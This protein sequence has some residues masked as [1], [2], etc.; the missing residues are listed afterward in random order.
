MNSGETTDRR[1]DVLGVGVSAQTM[2]QAVETVA[3]WIQNR[4]RTYVCVADVHSVV[5][6][7]GD[8]ALRDIH[9]AA[10]MVTT[11]G[12]PLVWLCRLAGRRDAER[13]YGPDLMLAVCE[14]SVRRGWKHYLYGG[15]ETTLRRLEANLVAGFPGLIIVGRH[16]PPFRPLTE[17]EDAAVVA[18][19]AGAGADIVWVG[20]GAPKQERWMAAHVGRLTTPVMI[21]VGAAFDF[22]AGT[23][24]QAPLWMRR[25]G[26]EWLFR[27]ACEPRRLGPRY[28]VNNT[29]FIIGLLRRALGFGAWGRSVR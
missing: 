14:H 20:L 24:P 22:H 12:M 4:A 28:L 2:T 6:T 10:G 17:E 15:D 21:G 19:I 27:M 9:N 8:P 1:V 29:L 26:L 23:K 7:L 3:G 5:E 13:V 18:D 16:A 25:N 11:D